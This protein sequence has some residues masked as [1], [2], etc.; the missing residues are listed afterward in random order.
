M[1]LP[2]GALRRGIIPATIVP[3][4]P[5]SGKLICRP[6]RLVLSSLHFDSKS[7]PTV[8]KGTSE[9]HERDVPAECNV[10]LPSYHMPEITGEPRCKVSTLTPSGTLVKY[11]LGF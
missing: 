7:L 9:L 3:V 2:E 4:S 1:T 5:S 10:T 8:R 6:G 11:L